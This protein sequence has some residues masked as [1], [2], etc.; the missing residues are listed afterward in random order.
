L[1]PD[2]FTV[3]A[4]LRMHD[5]TDGE[6]VIS[7][8]ATDSRPAVYV[9]SPDDWGNQ[10]KPLIY[11]NSENYCYFAETI[12]TE[13]WHVLAVTVPGSGQTDI[14]EAAFYLDGTPLTI[15]TAYSADSQ[16]SKGQPWLGRAGD[17]YGHMD[18]ALVAI[19]SRVIS[20]AETQRSYRSIARLYWD[21]RGICVSGWESHCQSPPLHAKLL[22]PW[23]PDGT[24]ALA[25]LPRKLGLVAMTNFD[26]VALAFILMILAFVPDWHPRVCHEPVDV[27]VHHEVIVLTCA[28]ALSPDRIQQITQQMRQRLLLHGGER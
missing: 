15:D 1:K 25:M 13:T 18:Q 23:Q 22:A 2:A 26:K 14:E 3:I 20:T 10:S 9:R 7:W 11:L 28:Q 4:V 21:Y 6:P 19:Y 12:E 5:A 17:Y 24:W 16:L 8:S 27:D